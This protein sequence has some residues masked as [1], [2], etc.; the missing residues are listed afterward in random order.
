MY[1]DKLYAALPLSIRNPLKRYMMS[2]LKSKLSNFYKQFIKKNSVVFDIGTNEGDYAE[3]FADLGAKVICLEPHPDYVNKLNLKFSKRKNVLV[4]PSGIGDKKEVREFHI[5]S[6]N[7]PNS[8]FSEDFRKNSR[9]NYR[10]WDRVI[11]VQMMTL[12]DLIKKYGKPD[13]CKVDVEGFEW[14]VLSSLKEIVPCISFEFLSEMHNKTQKIVRHLD[15]LGNARY[16][17]SL[18]MSY[19]FKF[20]KWLSGDELLNILDKNKSKN[21]YGDIYVKF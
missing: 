20:K 6:F 3:I 5:S 15:F 16:N 7:G 13:F 8:S 4:V 17:I 10:K 1:L 14:E 9:Y 11:K 18:G 12:E 19:R 21:W 2:Y